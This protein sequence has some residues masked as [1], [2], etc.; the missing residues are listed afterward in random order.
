[1]EP[2]QATTKKSPSCPSCGNRLRLLPEQIGTTIICPKCNATFAVGRP[3]AAEAAREG[4]AYEPEIPLK[5]SSIVPED[6][7]GDAA[8]QSA[9]SPQYDADWST[10]DHL[11]REPLHVRPLGLEPDY[12][13][14]AKAKGLMRSTDPESKPPKWTFFSGVFLFPWQG[15][16]L[17]R[18]AIMA[19]A[20]SAAG[21]IA[22]AALDFLGFLSRGVSG[23]SLMGIPLVL[24]G[25]F[26]LLTSLSYT[27]VC[28]L[29]AVQDT[30]DGHDRVQEDTMPELNQWFFTLGGMVL[31]WMAAGAIGYPFTFIEEI[32]PPAILVSSVF[33]FP[34]LVLS[35]MECDSFILPFSPP[36]LRSL[37][38]FWRGWMIF[39][40]M[41][42]LLLAG[43]LVLMDAAIPRAPYATAAAIGPIL[44]TISL[45]YARLLGRVAWKAAGM[46]DSRREKPADESPQPGKRKKKRRK[47]LFGS[48]EDLEAAASH[49]AVEL[50]NSAGPVNS[51]HRSK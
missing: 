3:P 36:I 18:W 44:A 48:P 42:T 47:M 20:L 17:A 30:A 19:C 31:L 15:P 43:C 13:E 29:A 35:A 40:L 27:S 2:Q 6:E 46:P 32:G 41:T 38:R 50:P 1:M 22:I 8:R 45:V 16:N 34:I 49:L 9:K 21:L 7:L 4:D 12:L 39:Y 24:V 14:I 23:T 5:R 10:E 51:R 11:E 26:L 33:L 28:F 37:L 25:V